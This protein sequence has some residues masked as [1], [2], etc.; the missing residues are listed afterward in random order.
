MNVDEFLS[1]LYGDELS[2]MFA[3][4]RNSKEESRIKLLPLMNTGMTYAYA[5]YK[6]AYDTVQL[7]VTADVEDYTISEE[8]FL[9][10]DAVVNAYGRELEDTEVQ[11]LGKQL[12]FYDPEEA[13]LQVVYKTKPVKFTIAQDD[14]DVDIV[15]PDLLIPWLKAYTCHRFFASMK[16]EEGLLA[17]ANFLNQATVCE[18]MFMNTNTTNEYTAHTNT[19][20]CSRGFP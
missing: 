7:M 16:T 19:K 2:D 3:G 4:N 10:V 12:H 15:L 20:L 9:A 17:A 5:K 8:D 11:I 14:E 18:Q 1:E 6:I 13:E